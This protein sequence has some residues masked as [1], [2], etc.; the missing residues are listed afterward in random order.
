MDDDDL[1]EALDAAAQR[2]QNRLTRALDQEDQFGFPIPLTD[3]AAQT[4]LAYLAQYRRLRVELGAGGGGTL[5]E[6][7]RDAEGL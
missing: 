3:A 7:E 4:Y 1:L 5:M 2:L 6:D